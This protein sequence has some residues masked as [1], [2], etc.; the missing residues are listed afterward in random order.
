MKYIISVD[1]S[2][3]G[4]KVLLI[5]PNGEIVLKLQKN[6]KQIIPRPGYVEHDMEEIYS[7]V[8][9]LIKE[10]FVKEKLNAKDIECLSITN[11]RETVVAWDAITGKP[12]HNAIVWQCSRGSE[13]CKLISKA[14]SSYIKTITGLPLSPYFSAAKI[15]WLINNVPLIADKICKNEICFGTVDSFLIYNLTRGEAFKT[16]VSNASR[17][18]LFNINTLRWDEK[19]C[20]IFKIPVNTLPNVVASDAYIGTTTI[21]NFIEEGIE[22]R[23]ILGDSQAALFGQ[24]CLEKGMLKATYGTGSSIMMNIGET[25]NFNSS[26]LVTSIGWQRGKDVIYVLEGNVNYAGSVISW[27]VDDLK[28][29][30]T[31]SDTEKCAKLAN[32]DDKCYLVPAFTGLGAPYWRSDVRAAFINM[33][34]TT[35]KNELVK[36]ALESIGYQINDILSRMKKITNIN[37]IELRVDGGPTKNTWLMQFQSDISNCLVSSS[38]ISELSA[39]GVAFIAG[40]QKK[41]FTT[42]IFAEKRNIYVPKMNGETRIEK[43]IGWEK[44][45]KMI[46]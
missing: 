28:L 2:T 32:V 31:P 44:A 24:G 42:N 16:D 35:G 11:Q 30:D 23:G 43:C 3:Q 46:L 36:A 34:R 21:E 29:V 39:M 1:Q 25:N 18:Q 13:V 20:S 15:G 41:Y 19:I 4:T 40:L 5:N 8:I 6:H 37:D 9:E 12:L 14:D 45:L 17:T 10:V 38:M 26:S 27:L 33:S 22:I 7:N